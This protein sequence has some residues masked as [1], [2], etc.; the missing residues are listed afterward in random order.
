M[1][2]NKVEYVG[3][4]YIVIEFYIGRQQRWRYARSEVKTNILVIK[5]KSIE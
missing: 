3:K 2:S 1:Y 5:G 4:I